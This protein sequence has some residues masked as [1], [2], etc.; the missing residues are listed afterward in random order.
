MCIY[1]L[2]YVV[3]FLSVFRTLWQSWNIASKKCIGKR[4]AVVP[5]LYVPLFS[6]RILHRQDPLRRVNNDNNNNN[7]TDMGSQLHGTLS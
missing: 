6:R 5:L 7:N 3:L 1:I 4:Y 2:L